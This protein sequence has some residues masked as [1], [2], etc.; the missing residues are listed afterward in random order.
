MN[1]IQHH[2]V[3][4]VVLVF[5]WSALCEPGIMYRSSIVGGHSVAF[6]PTKAALSLSRRGGNWTA[7]ENHFKYIH[8]CP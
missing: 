3:V 6:I 8:R 2:W 7:T 4:L 5:L 1:L